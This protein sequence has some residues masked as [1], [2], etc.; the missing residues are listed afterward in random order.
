MNKTLL[1][2]NLEINGIELICVKTKEDALNAAKEYIKTGISIGLG[3]SMSIEEIGLLKYILEKKDIKVFN[4]YEEG[5]DMNE[6]VKRRKSGMHANLYVSSTNALTQNGEL[7]NADGEGNRVA[8]QIFG[9]D[10]LLIIA[11]KNK[12]VKDIDE[13]IAR[14]YEVAAVK[15]AERLNKKAISYGKAPLYT[16]ENI[17]AKISIIKKD[18][19]GR[20]TIILVDE[21]LGY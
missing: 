15:N 16:T 17:V 18:K 13:G 8:A 9:S 1:K 14:T 19:K 5:I 7:I 2:E 11:G 3:G 21:D 6:N 10:K 12:L 4:Q 20:T